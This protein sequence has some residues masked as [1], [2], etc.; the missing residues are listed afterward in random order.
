MTIFLQFPVALYYFDLGNRVVKII[1]YGRGNPF[2]G[3][4]FLN[5]CVFVPTFQ[6][7]AYKILN[8]LLVAWTSY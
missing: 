2:L 7:D 3:E 8:R 4:Q 5:F 1:M 6:I